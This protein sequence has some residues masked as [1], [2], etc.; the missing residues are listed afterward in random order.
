LDDELFENDFVLIKEKNEYHI[1]VY[2][3]G[4]IKIIRY[5]VD[6]PK[7]QQQ[8]KNEEKEEET[9]KE[10]DKL[11]IEETRDTSKDK[12]YFELFKKKFKIPKDLDN[13]SMDDFFAVLKEAQ[14]PFKLFIQEIEEIET[15]DYDP[16][17]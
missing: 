13:L 9:N 8:I 17:D 14:K 10:L 4:V 5:N 6:T 16:V 2:S 12:Y 11:K 3:N 15:E 7:T 1:G